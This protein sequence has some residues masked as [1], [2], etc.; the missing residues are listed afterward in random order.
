[1]GVISMS[2]TFAEIVNSGVNLYANTEMQSDTATQSAIYDWYQFRRV[3]DDNRF[4]I[5]FK[6]VIN[7]TYLQY[8]Q[9]LRIEPGVVGDTGYPT[10]YDWLIEN[11]KERLTT[12]RKNSS[13]SVIENGSKNVEQNI[14][15]ELTNSG[16]DTN[17]KNNTKSGTDYSYERNT[18]SDTRVIDD[19]TTIDDDTTVEQEYDSGVTT[20]EKHTDEGGTATE[21]RDSALSRSF[22]ATASYTTGTDSQ[23]SENNTRHGFTQLNET[24][25]EI[26]VGERQNSEITGAAN[27]IIGL[28][29]AFPDLVIKNPSA[30][31]DTFTVTGGSSESLKKDHSSTS[32]DGKDTT[33][34]DGT[35]TYDN[36]KTD[37]LT[38]GKN[39]N[40]DNG[41]NHTDNTT[42]TLV[43]GHKQVTEGS[44]T[45]ESSTDLD[46]N[47]S[48]IARDDNTYQ[49]NGRS[50]DI[51]TLLTKAVKFIELTN[52]FEW[53][54]LQLESC[55]MQVLEED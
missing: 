12:D 14:N 44:N 7:E 18:G 42:E 11:Y 25:G 40:V 5:F 3:T 30:G 6:R 53:L 17:T 39:K 19:Y 1:M 22:P 27:H 54:T 36:D 33:T 10:N 50:T 13:E 52:A 15:N 28:H 24:T 20:D 9:L 49:S 47:T 23:M 45:L 34:T 16:T 21:V 4:P 43:H 51:A 2:K 37:T 8:R 46:R 31:A 32:R 55:F 26:H 48:I 41:H 35:K 29:R 38:Y